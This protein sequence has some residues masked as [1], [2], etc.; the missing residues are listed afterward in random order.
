MKTQKDQGVEGVVEVS[1]RSEFPIWRFFSIQKYFYFACALVAG[2]PKL[3]GAEN[4]ALVINGGY[5]D[6]TNYSLHEDDI[7][8]FAR[9]LGQRTQILNYNGPDSMVVPVLESGEMKRDQ[10]G[11]VQLETS[12][13]K[14]SLP[15]NPF[16]LSKVFADLIREKPN[17]LT[18]VYGDHGAPEGISLGDSVLRR[19]QIQNLYDRLPDTI[20]RSIHLHC[21]AESAMLDPE[22]KVPTKREDFLKF[23]SD[24]Y[25]KNRCG[26]ATSKADEV[27]QYYSWPLKPNKPSDHKSWEKMLLSLGKAS[28]QRIKEGLVGDSS[29]APSV[30]LTSDFMI[31]DVGSFVCK[32]T[33]NADEQT[34]AK[35]CLLCDQLS[36]LSPTSVLRGIAGI[37]KDLTQFQCSKCFDP[38]LK[39]LDLLVSWLSD[40]FLTVDSFY[41]Y[42]ALQYLVEKDPERYVRLKQQF[43]KLE[44]GRIEALEKATKK[45]SKNSDVATTFMLQQELFHE[46]KHSPERVRAA[47]D[48]RKELDYYSLSDRSDFEE[49][50]N[51]KI[52]RSSELPKELTD[53][54]SFIANPQKIT[55]LTDILG[56]QPTYLKVKKDYLLSEIY[57]L[58]I[59]LFFD[60]QLTRKNHYSSSEKYCKQLAEIFFERPENKIMKESYESIR[61]CEASHLN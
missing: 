40:S 21:Y 34:E 24:H 28:L 18:V 2:S 39:E 27:G 11:W 59:D 41:R 35:S 9:I 43:E 7:L 3:I 26:L 51:K 46:K 10:D 48:L 1:I 17:F 38:K 58:Y 4:A 15:A 19:S 42:H 50:A 12:K 31:R 47:L 25:S 29:F 23:F 44:G 52:L 8:A 33:L 22:R 36:R 53:L 54:L 55:Q 57:S 37:F 20:I 14:N 61:R 6:D 13:I 16:T 56:H 32:D 45:A 30:A 5:S 60:L 49:Y